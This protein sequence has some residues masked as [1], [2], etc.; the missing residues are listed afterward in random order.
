MATSGDFYVAIDSEHAFPTPTS[1][2]GVYPR[3]MRKR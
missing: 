1:V 2:P 3:A